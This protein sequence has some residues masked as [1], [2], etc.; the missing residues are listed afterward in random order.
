MNDF[1]KLID[2]TDPVGSVFAPLIGLPAWNV[3]KGQGSFLT[4]DFGAP[5][6]SITE[7]IAALATCDQFDNMGHDCSDSP[8]RADLC[9]HKALFRA[10][11]KSI[12]DYGTR[13]FPATR[14]AEM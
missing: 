14:G 13:D 7:P 10:K 4:F 12:S 5:H 11:G 3:Q 8:W 1:S 9:F 6:L 2:E